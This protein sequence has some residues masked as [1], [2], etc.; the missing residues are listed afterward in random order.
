MP[1]AHP[2]GNENFLWELFEYGS[3]A[4]LFPQQRELAQEWDK[5]LTRWRLSW[6]F[7]VNDLDSA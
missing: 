4:K 6:E 5:V 2:A 1:G 3:P 7:R